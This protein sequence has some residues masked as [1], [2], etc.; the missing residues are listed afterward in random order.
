MASATLTPG[1]TVFNYTPPVNLNPSSYVPNDNLQTR[2]TI[3]FGVFGT[4]LALV[5]IIVSGLTLRVYQTHGQ[6]YDI[7]SV[8]P[9]E[10][11]MQTLDVH[12]APR[13]NDG[14]R[15][16]VGRST[17]DTM[18][19]QDE[20]PQSTCDRHTGDANRGVGPWDGDIAGGTIVT[21]HNVVEEAKGDNSK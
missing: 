21:G 5:G 13:E 20:P 11:Q 17:K 7:E 18:V 10:V 6:R 19:G 16:S 4:F 14:A 12:H 15:N 9:F 2:A 1:V 8:L 3:V